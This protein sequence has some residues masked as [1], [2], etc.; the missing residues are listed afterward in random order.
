MAAARLRMIFTSEELRRIRIMDSGNGRLR[1]I[2]DV[3]GMKCW[4]ARHFINNIINV[5]RAGF[6]FEIINGY[7]HGTAIKKMLAQNFNN[8]HIM[9]RHPDPHNRG[10]TYLSIAV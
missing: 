3:H 8:D 4:E 6:Q 10:V 7:N 9:E 1:I 5:I 2:A